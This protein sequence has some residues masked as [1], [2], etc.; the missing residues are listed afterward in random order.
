MYLNYDVFC[1]HPLPPPTLSHLPLPPSAFSLRLP[2]LFVVCCSSCLSCVSFFRCSF[3]WP[4]RNQQTATATANLSSRSCSLDPR[5]LPRHVL[6]ECLESALPACKRPERVCQKGL[7]PSRGKSLS[8]W[9]CCRCGC[10]WSWGEC[11]AV[12]AAAAAAAEKY[13][14]DFVASARLTPLL[15]KKMGKKNSKKRLLF[16]SV[17]FGS[18]QI[19]YHKNTPNK[20]AT[21]GRNMRKSMHDTLRLR[22]RPRSRSRPRCR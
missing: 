2:L 8:L 1:L 5:A 19:N 20:N 18:A 22:S 3:S 6:D 9:F 15:A 17:W 13:R 7:L 11:A 21:G 16:S 10:R 4:Q 14:F 12:V